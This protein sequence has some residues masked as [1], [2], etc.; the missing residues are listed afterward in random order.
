MAMPVFVIVKTISPAIATPKAIKGNAFLKGIPKTTAISEAVHPPVIGK[1][2]ATKAT[3][4]KSP[5]FFIFK[6]CLCFVFEKSRE[7]N[8]SDIETFS[9]KKD[10]TGRNKKRIRKTGTRLPRTETKYAKKG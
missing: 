9:E 2:I 1:G 6:E 10:E 4:A 7:K 8:L 3:K 5:Y